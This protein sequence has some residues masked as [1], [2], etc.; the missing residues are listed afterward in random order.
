MFSFQQKINP[1]HPG[2]NAFDSD[3]NK[4]AD[5]VDFVGM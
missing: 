3:M 5:L 2:I 4:I 1:P